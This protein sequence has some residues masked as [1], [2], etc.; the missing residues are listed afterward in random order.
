[1]SWCEIGPGFLRIL[2]ASKNFEKD[3]AFGNKVRLRFNGS[4]L[5]VV[6]GSDDQWIEAIGDAK[7]SGT[8]DWTVNLGTLLSVVDRYRHDTIKITKSRDRVAVGE[9]NMPKEDVEWPPGPVEDF[10]ST[11][12]FD[13]KDFYE[14]MSWCSQVENTDASKT[15]LHGTWIDLRTSKLWSSNERV[16]AEYEFDSM[17]PD[18]VACALLSY[19]I[20][21]T[22]K[23]LGYKGRTVI[24][25]SNDWARIEGKCDDFEV[26]Y[27]GRV[28]S[29]SMPQFEKV[30]S[31]AEK[32]GLFLSKSKMQ[33]FVSKSKVVDWRAAIAI[34]GSQFSY[35]SKSAAGFNFS[36]KAVLSEKVGQAEGTYNVK[37]LKESVWR[38]VGDEVGL[39]FVPI[40]TGP[41]MMLRIDSDKRIAHIMP[42]RGEGSSTPEDV[43]V[44]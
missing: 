17:R 38:S 26:S 25:I 4:R 7:G 6:T 28:R 36:G 24:F 18:G 30:A 33:D 41:E 9:F 31:W 5:E 8:F 37:F 29:T 34:D 40:P 22:L 10:G 35:K 14:G 43:P 2:H 44:G 13:A 11:G 1:M 3:G 32:C 19:Q 23:A 15:Y 42:L 16:V 12:V 21:W 27:W 39:G 20:C